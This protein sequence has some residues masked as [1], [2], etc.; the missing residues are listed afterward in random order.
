MSQ[1]PTLLPLLQAACENLN[2]D[3]RLRAYALAADAYYVAASVL[4]KMDD[5]GLAWLAA[6]RSM[7]AATLSPERLTIGSSAG[8]SPTQRGDRFLRQASQVRQRLLLRPPCSSR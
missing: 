2:G 8:S 6:D 4:L 3:V 5:R 7:Q 1:M